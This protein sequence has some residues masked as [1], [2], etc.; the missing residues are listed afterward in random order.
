MSNITTKPV[1][2]SEVDTSALK[3]SKLNTLPSGCKTM[4]VNHK[5]D[6]APLFVQSPEMKV[7]FDSGTY[8]PENETSGKFSLK[9]S[10]DN[11]DSNESMKQFHDMLNKMDQQ[12]IDDGIKNSAE[13]FKSQHKLE[14]GERTAEDIKCNA[15]SAVRCKGVNISVKGR[16]LITGI[17][18]AAYSN[19]IVP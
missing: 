2:A 6:F 12:F 15:G 4:Y 10:M 18:K 11:I 13:W 16:D 14:V 8:Y 19:P 17:P 3:Y 9:V 5:G 1:K 7:P